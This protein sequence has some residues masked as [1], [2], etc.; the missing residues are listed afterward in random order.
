M[1]LSAPKPSAA[2]AWLSGTIEAKGSKLACPDSSC[3]GSG[4]LRGEDHFKRLLMAEEIPLSTSPKPGMSP[5]SGAPGAVSGRICVPSGSRHPAPG[6][7]EVISECQL[8]NPLGWWRLCW[9]GW[10]ECCGACLCSGGCWDGTPM[11][12]TL[13][14][15]QL[16]S[17]STLLPPGGATDLCDPLPTPGSGC[18]A[19]PPFPVSPPLLPALCLCPELG[20]GPRSAPWLGWQQRRPRCGGQV[21]VLVGDIWHWFWQAETGGSAAVCRQLPPCPLAIG[22]VPAAST[23]GP[24]GLHPPS[25]VPSTLPLWPSIP[26]PPALYPHL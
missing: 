1:E 14:A 9:G 18:P 8:C 11:C 26:V 20:R 3:P 6:M 23:P 25:T 24:C 7:E 10:V 15:P 22:H 12:A 2:P 13:A 17:R 16:L 21:P 19:S 4:R 5:R